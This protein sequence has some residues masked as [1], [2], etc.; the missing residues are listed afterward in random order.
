MRLL[1]AEWLV[2]PFVMIF[3]AVNIRI[4][5]VFFIISFKCFKYLN[6]ISL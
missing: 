1:G 6:Y 2:V 3:T 4:Y 5:S